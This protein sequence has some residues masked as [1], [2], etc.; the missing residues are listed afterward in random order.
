MEI[1][2]VARTVI[3]CTK[4]IARG[5]AIRATRSLLP[6]VSPCLYRTHMPA[7]CGLERFYRELGLAKNSSNVAASLVGAREIHESS[8]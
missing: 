5:N 4:K 3:R 1:D 8:S 7:A 6:H 2:H